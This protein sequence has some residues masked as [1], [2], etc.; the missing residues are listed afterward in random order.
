MLAH[1]GKKYQKLSLV[2]VFDRK[3]NEILQL[4]NADCKFGYRTSI[5]N[6]SDKNRFIVLAVSY[7][8]K[9]NGTPKI[10]YRDILSHFGDHQPTLKETR[11]AVLNIRRAKSMVIDENDVNSRSAGSFF[12]NPIVTKIKFEEIK[13]ASKKLNIDRV[14][15][16]DYDDKHVKIP[17]AWLIE[18]SGFT[19]GFRIG[20]VG[21]SA[22]HSLAL[23]NLG[24]AEA[25]EI[26]LLKQEIQ[27][28]VIETF[29]VEI[30]PEPVFVG[31]T[32]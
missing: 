28:S 23:I 13:E 32:E 29:N 9:L 26:L 6:T 27:K 22:K 3:S 16:F 18:Q 12:K 5:F 30:N 24:G 1:T 15:S 7:Y 31:F 8:L 20:N 25:K 11:D 2:R 17:A 19:K 4:T 21:L 14:P 10:A